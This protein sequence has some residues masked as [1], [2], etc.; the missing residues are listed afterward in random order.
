MHSEFC[1]VASHAH[2]RTTR[3]SDHYLPTYLGVAAALVLSFVDPDPFLKGP[4]RVSFSYLLSY[5]P[6]SGRKE[7]LNACMFTEG[8]RRSRGRS[9]ALGQAFLLSLC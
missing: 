2:N 5:L 9:R 6:C 1:L 7:V 8:V 3:Q 4:L